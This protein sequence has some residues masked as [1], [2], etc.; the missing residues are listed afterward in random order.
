MTIGRPGFLKA[1]GVNGIEE[2][3]QSI[4]CEATGY[5]WDDLK[6]SDD[7]LSDLGMDSL[8]FAELELDAE[9]RLGCDVEPNAFT[10]VKTVGQLREKLLELGGKVQ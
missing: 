9:K 7:L 3:V 10:E 6:M 1:L 5:E 2:T 8:E 4:I